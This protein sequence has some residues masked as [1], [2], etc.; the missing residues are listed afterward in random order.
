VTSGTDLRSRC[1][2][3]FSAE[4]NPALRRL[5]A[6]PRGAGPQAPVADQD[7]AV[8]AQVWAVLAGLG[9]LG[10]TRLRDL[11][12]VA[13]Q[14]G[15]ALYTSPF[16]DTVMM[17]DLLADEADETHRAAAAAAAAGEQTFALAVRRHGTDEVTGICELSVNHD[18]RVSAAR[19]FVSFAAD[20][21]D[22]CLIGRLGAKTV[23]ARVAAS[24]PGV[25]VRRQDD[26]G[27]GDLYEV[28]CDRAPL[29]GSVVD[30]TA[31]YP[32]A[33]AR[34]RIRHAAYLAAAAAAAVELTCEYLRGRQ[35]FGQPL[36]KFQAP[37]FRL[38]SHAATAAAVAALARSAA[39][40]A[41]AGADVGGIAAQVLFLAADLIREAAADAVHLHGAYGMTES[42]DAQVFYRRA[43]VEACWL[44]T[45]TDLR[46]EA[47]A[48][49]TAAA[50]SE[51]GA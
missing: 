4:L 31:A 39:A 37:A 7:A 36:A 27:R 48:H 25:T 3:L 17:I 11:T 5:G 19:R 43:A 24:G 23:L 15:A 22:V 29:R 46:S 51:P 18:A 30:V 50:R 47:A 32:A 40:D 33:L 34:A 44:G 38:A 8:R 45:P 10:A 1:G 9:A 26:I 14:A 16:A 20:V 2:E 42:C 12:D 49:L 13:E 28:T 35:A 6:R 21:D 41:D